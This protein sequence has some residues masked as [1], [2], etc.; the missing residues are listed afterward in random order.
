[1]HPVFVGKYHEKRE[2]VCTSPAC[3][4]AASEILYSLSSN[5]KNIDPCTRFDE[6]VC[7]GWMERHDLRP[8]QGCESALYHCYVTVPTCANLEKLPSQGQSC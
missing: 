3:V 1:M 6:F 7:G 5:R 4:H 2:P 8:D